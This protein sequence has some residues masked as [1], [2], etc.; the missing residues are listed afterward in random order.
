M[1]GNQWEAL[2]AVM[3]A[4]E[5]IKVA[6]ASHP[7]VARAIFAEG[8]NGPGI[9]DLAGC[10]WKEVSIL[11]EGATAWIIFAEAPVAGADPDDPA[12]ILQNGVYPGIGQAETRVGL[13]ADVNKIIKTAVELE[14]TAAQRSD[15]DIPR[16]VLAQR[17]SSNLQGIAGIVWMGL[18]ADVPS[19]VA[20][21]Q[22]DPKIAAD[23]K[24]VRLVGKQARNAKAGIFIQGRIMAEGAGARIEAI[25]FRCSDDPDQS[26]L[27]QANRVIGS[28]ERGEG[29]S[30]R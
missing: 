13:G 5:P 15:P 16:R 24:T 18:Q 10:L 29:I 7:Q 4:V 14:E 27:I 11:A 19:K 8:F 25:Q 23:P 6:H 17:G 22:P 3:A 1:G 9:L 26:A 21:E 2:Q 20:I 30:L 28:T 12:S